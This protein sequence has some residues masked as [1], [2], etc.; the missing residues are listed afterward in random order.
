[1]RYLC[2]DVGRSD[3]R[4]VI[5]LLE[6]VSVSSKTVSLDETGG[7]IISQELSEA[8]ESAR[9]CILV[10]PD[11]IEADDEQTLKPIVWA[12]LGAM[13]YRVGPRLVVALRDGDLSADSF[14]NDLGMTVVHA[15]DGESVYP[16]LMG[17]LVESGIVRIS[18]G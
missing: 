17:A 2:W 9:G 8:L 12:T 11:D 18:V 6:G 13:S 5:G 14:E 16:K 1:M 3:S 10:W 15:A 4:R 7:R